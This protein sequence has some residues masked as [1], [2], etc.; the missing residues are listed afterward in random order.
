MEIPG[1]APFSGQPTLTNPLTQSNQL[2]GRETQ[3][4]SGSET[5]NTVIASEQDSTNLSTVDVVEQA[6]E[7]ESAGFDERNPGGTIDLTA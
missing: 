6:N 3:S 7:T 1:I 4:Q 2:V 5:Q